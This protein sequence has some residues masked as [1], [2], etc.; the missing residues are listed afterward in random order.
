MLRR[1][2]GHFFSVRGSLCWQA[3]PLSRTT[4]GRR[5]R[6]EVLAETG[7]GLGRIRPP[8]RSKSSNRRPARRFL[9]HTWLMFVYTLPSTRRSTPR[10]S[11]NAARRPAEV[12]HPL[13]RAAFFR[14]AAVAAPIACQNPPNLV[15][16][17]H[18]RPVKPPARGLLHAPLIAEKCEPGGLICLRPAEL[19]PSA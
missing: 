6:H 17:V 8:S 7:S 1:R 9:L 13:Y 4:R 15:F 2:A 12:H 14:L 3:R 16:S 5:S 19:I 11:R 18:L 10:L